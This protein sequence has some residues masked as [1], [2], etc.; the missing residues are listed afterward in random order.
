MVRLVSIL[1]E[2]VGDDTSYPQTTL[3]HC[4]AGV[5]LSVSYEQENLKPVRL[6][7]SLFVT[8]LLN[9]VQPSLNYVMSL[10]LSGFPK[11]DQL[12]GLILSAQ[13]HLDLQLGAFLLQCPRLERSLLLFSCVL[14]R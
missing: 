1:R 2:Y 11:K 8:S 4:E 12:L 3:P 7:L 6:G 5:S 9:S 10:L 13:R 14:K